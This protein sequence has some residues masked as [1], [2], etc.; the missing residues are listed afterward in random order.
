MQTSKR[1]LNS[2]RK[3]LRLRKNFWDSK[4][5]IDYRYSN[6]GSNIGSALIEVLVEKISGLYF[7]EYCKKYILEPVTACYLKEINQTIV[8]PYDFSDSEYDV[9]LHIFRL[10][11][12]RVKVYSIKC[13]R[14]P[15]SIY[16]KGKSHSYQLLKKNTIS[17]MMKEQISNIDDSVGLHLFELDWA[18]DLW[19][20]NGGEMGRFNSGYI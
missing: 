12:W 1:L 20:H 14:I 10:F 9:S 17:K 4:P 8:I 11:E 19:L 3:T 7:A 5:G 18:E 2:Q 13:V 6:I 15:C 16:S